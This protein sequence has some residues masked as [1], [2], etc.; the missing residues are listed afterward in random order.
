MVFLR[1]RGILER[2]EPETGFTAVRKAA[3]TRPGLA[4]GR[5]F[6]D[7]DEE[8]VGYEVEIVELLISM[9]RSWVKEVGTDGS[10]G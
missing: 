3:V 1:V 9:I 6:E 8:V 2:N 7:A 4:R 5:S 10:C